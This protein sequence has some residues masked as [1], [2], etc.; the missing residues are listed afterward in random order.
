MDAL[1]Q[2]LSEWGVDH[3][4]RGDRRGAVVVN[5]EQSS[6]YRAVGHSPALQSTREECAER[7]HQGAKT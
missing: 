3:L 4:I 2:F 7:V 1:E 5:E 6:S